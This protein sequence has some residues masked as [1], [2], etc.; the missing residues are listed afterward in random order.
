MASVGVLTSL[1]EAELAEWLAEVRRVAALPDEQALAGVDT[2]VWSVLEWHATQ[3]AVL[4]IAAGGSLA[5]THAAD[6]DSGW[7][8]QLASEQRALL[9]RATADLELQATHPGSMKGWEPDQLRRRANHLGRGASPDLYATAHRIADQAESRYWAC[10]LERLARE[11]LSSAA[12]LTK[13]LTTIDAAV[14]GL[15]QLGVLS[16]TLIAMAR[17]AKEQA[18]WFRARKRLDDAA[19]AQAGAQVGKRAF[20]LRS[21]AAVML[22]QDWARVF[23]G[24]IPPPL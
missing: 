4:D 17:D 1:S 19:V 9:E 8:A 16:P 12:G 14:A 6:E 13:R 2:L 7:E 21:E 3:R 18:A 11:P 5:V 24:E 10:T 23:P 15:K 20:K 22:Q